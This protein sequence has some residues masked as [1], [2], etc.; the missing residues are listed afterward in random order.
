MAL[1]LFDAQFYAYANPDLAAAGLDTAEEL[2]SHFQNN[3]LKEGRKF[4]PF[5]DLEF[6]KTTNYQLESLGLSTNEE[7]Y[8]NL[9]NFGVKNGLRFSQVLDLKYYVNTYSDLTQAFGTD[10]EQAFQHLQTFGLS[11]NRDFVSD[12]NL[13]SY[14]ANNSDV[15]IAAK[16]ERKLALEHLVVFGVNEP[17]VGIPEQID[18]N[19][20]QLE[21]VKQLIEALRT[22]D[23]DEFLSLH[24][25]NATWTVA[26][27]KDLIPFAEE[28]YGTSGVP[29][30]TLDDF[31]ET[32]QQTVTVQEF[33]PL[34]YFQDDNEIFV[35]VF[36]NAMVASNGFPYKLDQTY[37]IELG[38]TAADLDQIKSVKVIG[39]S[40]VIAEAIAGK[41]PSQE[42][43]NVAAIDPM[44]GIDLSVNPNADSEESLAVAVDAYT[45][46]GTGGASAFSE[47]FTDDAVIDF[48]GDPSILPYAGVESGG[49]SAVVKKFSDLNTYVQQTVFNGQERIANG[50]RV[51][52]R[53]EEELLSTG[54]LSNGEQLPITFETINF[55]TIRDGK[56]ADF[57]AVLDTFVISSAVNPDAVREIFPNLETAGEPYL[58]FA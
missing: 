54:L 29:G 9:V 8:D 2:L 34:D 23:K 51:V 19:S 11:E 13:T 18:S 49:P 31:F 53:N 3:G 46:F 38:N 56:I 50:D 4:S 25:Y 7:W 20:V 14:L 22:G 44:T 33:Q 39:N 47:N 12:L 30:Q 24:A 37:I 41:A 45:D 28:W 48:P 6:Y 58:I 36:E 17:R 52:A 1:D 40:F 42:A 55:L 5:I 32:R 43:L 57:Q 15:D 21:T 27:R 16:G 35:R 26:G 10:Y